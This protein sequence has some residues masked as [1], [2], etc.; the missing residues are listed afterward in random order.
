MA[1]FFMRRILVAISILALGAISSFSIAIFYILHKPYKD[2]K[3]IFLAILSEGCFFVVIT[4]IF[5][6]IKLDLDANIINIIDLKISGVICIRMLLPFLIDQFDLLKKLYQLVLRRF[7]NRI[8][9]SI[10]QTDLD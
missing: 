1:Y 7:I 4:S 8:R 5:S 10:L 2:K 9:R 6:I 3:Q